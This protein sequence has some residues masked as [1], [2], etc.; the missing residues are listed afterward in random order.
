MPAIEATL[1]MRPHSRFSMSRPAACANRNAPVR[2][3]STTFCHLSSGSTSGSAPQVTPALLIRTSTFPNF[4]TVLSTTACTSAAFDTSQ[5]MPST[6]KPQ[7]RNASTVGVS[8]SSRR[9]HSMSDAPASASP[10]A[11]SWPRPREPPVTIATRS[12]RL[13]NSLM[14]GTLSGL[15]F[16]PADVVNTGG[17]SGPR[18]DYNNTHDTNPGTDRRRTVSHGRRQ[19][20]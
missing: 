13:N 6:V 8:H 14:V 11:I 2:L 12:F 5:S 18:Y 4:D 19:P 16:R 1:M 9:A 3:M 17:S 15:Y 10:S 7:A 20:Q